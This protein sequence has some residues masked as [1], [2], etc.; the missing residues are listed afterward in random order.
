MQK[1]WKRTKLGVAAIILA[2]LALSAAPAGAYCNS[3]PCRTTGVVC[4]FCTYVVDYGSF[5]C[6]YTVT[7]CVDCNTG[8]WIYWDQ[9]EDFC[10]YSTI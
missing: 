5:W 4:S 2:T 8:D 7:Y 9:S 6:R 10:A 3:D 1:F